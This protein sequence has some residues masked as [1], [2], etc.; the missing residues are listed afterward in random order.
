MAIHDTARPLVTDQILK[1]CYDS[2]KT[3]GNGVAAKRISD[4]IK[5]TDKNT[6]VI[7]TI[8]RTNLWAI[9]T[10]QVLK[11]KKYSQHIIKF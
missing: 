9:E 11:Q 10:P 3:F 5:R 1:K 8:D 4:T 6:K 7:E 2:C